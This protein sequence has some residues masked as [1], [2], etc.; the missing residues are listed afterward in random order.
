M[1][2]A[3][4]EHPLQQSWEA[5]KSFCLMSDGRVVDGPQDGSSHSESQGYGLLLAATFAD[6]QAFDLIDAWTMRHLDVRDDN[7]LAWRWLPDA[8]VAVPDRNN[9]SDGDLF[10]AW[11]LVRAASTLGRPALLDRATAIAADLAQICVVASPE[12]TSRLLFVPAAAGFR[13]GD[14]IIVNPSYYMPLAMRE[15]ARAT[16]VASLAR[17]ADD[18]LSLIADLTMSGRLVP[19]WVA[20]SPNG[21]GSVSELSADFGYEAVRVALFL[22]W[23]GEASHPAVD[24]HRTL[25]RATARSGEGTATRARVDSHEVLERSADPGYAAIGGLLECFADPAGAPGVLRFSVRQ[26]YYPA[27]LHLFALL[28]QIEVVPECLPI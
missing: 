4:G 21:P 7:L 6:A 24:R 20:V 10:Y 14:T 13:R 15:L 28:S 2:F 22:G 16:G 3:Q 12:P 1:G 17:V 26:P 18:G 8:P 23:S 19:D 27:T 25:L 11:A 9:A 5:W